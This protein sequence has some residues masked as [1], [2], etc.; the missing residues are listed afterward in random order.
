MYPSY[1]Q[2]TGIYYNI[3]LIRFLQQCMIYE[4]KKNFLTL[5]QFLLTKIDNENERKFTICISDMKRRAVST[6]HQRSTCMS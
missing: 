2:Y 6:L 1:R 3:E 4:S 5:F